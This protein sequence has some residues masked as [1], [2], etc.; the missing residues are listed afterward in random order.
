[1]LAIAVRK[2]DKKLIKNIAKNTPKY[3]KIALLFWYIL[4]P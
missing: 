1:M 3:G 2:T 4:F